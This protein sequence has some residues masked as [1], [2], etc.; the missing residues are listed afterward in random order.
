MSGD[1]AR[2]MGALLGAGGGLGAAYG[3]RRVRSLRLPGT[4]DSGAHAHALGALCP[5]LRT[6]DARGP[7]ALAPAPLVAAW[8]TAQSADLLAQLRG[9]VRFLDLR[10]CQHSDPADSGHSVFSIHHGLVG[11]PLERL[12]GQ[13]ALFL[14]ESPRELVVVQLS[15]LCA[16]PP[17]RPFAHAALAALVRAALGPLALSRAAALSPGLRLAEALAQG[18]RALVLYDGWPPGDDALGPCE[19]PPSAALV[20]YREPLGVD[21]TASPLVLARALEDVVASLAS[22]NGSPSGDRLL[23][24]G[25]C[26]TPSASAIAACTAAMRP[27]LHALAGRCVALQRAFLWRHRC[28]PVHV[29]T[30]DFYEETPVVQ[31][32]ID[33]SAADAAADAADAAAPARSPGQRLCYGVCE[34]RE[35]ALRWAGLLRECVVGSGIAVPGTP[36]CLP[37]GPRQRAL[38]VALVNGTPAP[39]ALEQCSSWR[40]TVSALPRLVP[41]AHVAASLAL[42]TSAPA[43]CASCS[44]AVVGADH[45][46][47]LELGWNKARLDLPLLLLAL[48][49]VRVELVAKPQEHAVITVEQ[50]AEEEHAPGSPASSAAPALILSTTK[51]YQAVAFEVILRVGAGWLTQNGVTDE[52][53]RLAATGA[54][55]FLE[56]RESGQPLES[57]KRCCSGWRRASSV[58]LCQNDDQMEVR[59]EGDT[60]L[61]IYSRARSYCNSSRLHFGGRVVIAV[62]IRDSFG[63]TISRVLSEPFSLLSKRTKSISDLPSPPPA[64]HTTASPRA[65]PS[66][67]YPSAPFTIS[68]PTLPTEGG[69]LGAVDALLSDLESLEKMHTQAL[70]RTALLR[71]LMGLLQ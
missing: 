46:V 7:A 2:W 41:P 39:L 33:A 5:R 9:G 14:R 15:H 1:R 37:A 59:E 52:A 67:P 63:R 68:S 65:T 18:S 35:E 70:V 16:L 23:R 54:K 11:P 64:R 66:T 3:A 17:G 43:A 38:C 57:C 34:S 8:A 6:R 50:A 69:T 13:V 44:Y 26:L 71:Q 40:C 32:A 19:W 28:A 61:F 56:G 27:G 29:V 31:W 55:L 10:V 45:V 22:G 58:S 49:S 21:G 53:V 51:V 12:L 36:F 42:F 24:L 30:V 25:L 4:H 20:D 60:R 62:E 47:D 48:F